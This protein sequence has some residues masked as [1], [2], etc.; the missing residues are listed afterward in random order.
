MKMERINEG[1]IKVSISKDEL[2][3]RGINL[4]SFMG[5]EEDFHD[6]LVSLLDEIDTDDDF[7]E[8]G[9]FSFQIMV[10]NNNLIV[11]IKNGSKLNGSPDDNDEILS[12]LNNI[13][14]DLTNSTSDNDEN[15]DDSDSNDD[16]DEEHEHT[17]NED[18]EYDPDALNT[19]LSLSLAQYSDKPKDLEKYMGLIYPDVVNKYAPR[20]N[21]LFL[22]LKARRILTM[23]NF[24]NEK[25]KDSGL[26][27][28]IYYM[29]NS[30]IDMLKA[31]LG[32]SDD[33]VDTDKQ[34]EFS[35]ADQQLKQVKQALDKKENEGYNP[36]E[37]NVLNKEYSESKQRNSVNHYWMKFKNFDDVIRMS[38][39]VENREFIKSS[40]YKY[41]DNYVMYFAINGSIS[42]DE[43]E[44]FNRLL[45]NADEYGVHVNLDG[46]KLSNPLIQDNALITV[47]RYFG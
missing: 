31:L 27:K 16:F 21:E 8:N 43:Q 14:K 34:L 23:L 38:L 45:I 17:E 18:K 7:K 39:S 13:S 40:L 35:I 9:A 6:F 12:D 42:D 20:S 4:F 36:A 3:E 15:E 28:S 25:N 24:L 30:A 46:Q 41:N 22:F 10:S 33:A 29:E 44:A 5:N 47:E 1:T 37:K 19:M 32:E 2:E 11:Y 26:N